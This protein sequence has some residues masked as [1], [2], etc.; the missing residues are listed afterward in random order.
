MPRADYSITFSA[1][2]ASGAE[3]IIIGYAVLKAP[4]GWVLATAANRALYGRRADGLALESATA[5][6]AFRLAHNG[7]IDSSITGLDDGDTSWVRVADSGALVRVAD[8]SITEDHDLVGRCTEDGDLHIAC[9]TWTSTNAVGTGGSGSPGSHDLNAANSRVKGINGVFLKTV[10]GGTPADEAAPPIGGTWVYNEL[11][12][13]TGLRPKKPA[14]PGHYDFEDYG[15]VPDWNGTTG[16]DNAD[17]WDAMLA[18]SKA[19][20]NESAKILCHGHYYFSRT[21]HIEQTIHIRGSGNGQPEHLTP[22]SSSTNPG[23]MFVFP[24]NTKGLRFHGTGADDDGIGVGGFN[25][26]GMSS[27]E[28][29]IVTNK[30][31]IDPE[32]DPGAHG[33][34]FTD[35]LYASNVWVNGFPGCGWRGNGSFLSQYDGNIDGSQLY[36]CGGGANGVDGL[37]LTGSDATGCTIVGFQANLNRR[38]GIFDLTRQNTY[39]QCLCQNNAAVGLS[40]PLEDPRHGQ[41]YGSNYHTESASGETPGYNS[42]TFIGCYSE[43]NTA[44]RENRMF[45]DVCCFGGSLGESTI[46]E[47]SSCFFSEAGVAGRKHYQYHNA[48]GSTTINSLLGSYEPTDVDAMDAFGWN[49][50]DPLDFSRLRYTDNEASDIHRWWTLENVSSARPVIRYPTVQS[51]ARAVAPWLCNGILLGNGGDDTEMQVQLAAS[52]IPTIDRQSLPRTYKQG[53]IVWRNDSAPGDFAG[54]YCTTAGTYGTLTGVTADTTSASD[55][56]EVNNADELVVG[57]YITIAGVTGTKQITE[58]DVTTVTVDSVCDA[59]VSDGAVAWSAPVFKGF[60]EIDV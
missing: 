55:E 36:N 28:G 40:A 35:V 42:S 20:G 18:I 4:S 24:G 60:A 2:V 9:N 19:N 16:T 48:R 46:H 8:E 32:D 51:G 31:A 23:T 49:T 43:G 38:Y 3:D 44:G 41:S 11:G 15:G 27:I 59:T 53:D 17:A 1:V 52:A 57:Q 33:I 30:D 13:T 45:G 21:L 6:H 14:P 12:S 39:V 56:I 10:A 47:D 34:H 26:S 37:Q 5:R 29:F 25:A 7:L 22:S 58:I 50:E 54:D